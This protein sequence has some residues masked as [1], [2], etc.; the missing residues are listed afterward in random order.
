MFQKSK[1][2]CSDVP[3]I[4]SVYVQ[5]F[6]KLECPEKKFLNQSVHVQMFCKSEDPGQKLWKSEF[7]C[8]DVLL[9]VHAFVVRVLVFNFILSTLCFFPLSL[10][11]IKR[12]KV[13]KRQKE[14]RENA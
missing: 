1:F 3:E 7:P 10:T 2:P 8:P 12:Q 11:N 13:H 5:M 14:K 6:C 9:D 4:R